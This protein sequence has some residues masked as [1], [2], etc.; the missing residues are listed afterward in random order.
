M[1]EYTKALDAIQLAAEHDDEHK[2]TTEI[3]QHMIKI[4]QAMMSERAGETDEQT[5]A[6]AMKDPEVAQIMNDPVMRSILEQAQ[7]DPKSLQDH[8]KN[9]AIRQNITKLVNAGILRTGR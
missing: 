1:R 6:R 7:S 9:P 4:Q 3:Q 8:M 5:M 2:S